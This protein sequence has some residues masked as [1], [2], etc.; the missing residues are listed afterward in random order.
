MKP[1]LKCYVV[2]SYVIGTAL[3]YFTNQASRYIAEPYA[4]LSWLIIKPFTT[5]YLFGSTMIVNGIPVIFEDICTGVWLIGLAAMFL[6]LR[7]SSKLTIVVGLVGLFAL[8]T[9]RIALVV[10]ALQSYAFPIA[11]TFHDIFYA[12][13]TGTAVMISLYG[14]WPLLNEKKVPQT[15]K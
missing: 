14:A 15:K 3:L 1:L 12:I 6:W 8:N 4:Y 11:A 13:F 9:L 5:V 2:L 10:L 7:G